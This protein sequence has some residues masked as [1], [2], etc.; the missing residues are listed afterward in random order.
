MLGQMDIRAGAIVLPGAPP[1][2]PTFEAMAREGVELRVASFEALLDG[3]IPYGGMLV[4][5][6]PARVSRLRLTTL[7]TW[8][9]ER[10]PECG[11]LGC[12]ADGDAED[13][14]NALEAGFDDFVAGRRS[15][16]ELAARLRVL[17]RRQGASERNEGLRDR[18]R[19][20]RLTLDRARHELWMG[21]K[22]FPLTAME[23]ELMWRLASARGRAM[24]R[25]ELLDSVWGSDNL[26]VG[27][28][29]VDN[30]IQRLRRKVGAAE[31]VRTVRG[32]GFR[33][34]EA[35]SS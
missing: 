30:L 6:A 14:E 26:E 31:I 35:G 20:G 21:E 2:D 33:V 11:L 16:R 27:P 17:A 24:T 25:T 22:C 3:E 13:S 5:W 18:I 28:R 1:A 19:F 12:A 8:R 7:G 10:C 15:A 34:D 23:M 32:I 4:V 9:R 29:A